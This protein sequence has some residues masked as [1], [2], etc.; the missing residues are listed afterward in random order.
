[1]KNRRLSAVVPEQEYRR[2]E[3]LV[4]A[5]FA[6]STADLIRKAV[7]EYEQRVGAEKLLNL[8]TVPMRQARAEIQRYLK[9][10][11]GTVWPDEMAEELGLDYRLVLKI[12]RELLKEEKVEVVRPVEMIKA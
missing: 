3:K 5:G 6:R 2:V 1:M 10:H 4:R 9:A 11:H 12:V 8:R 7:R